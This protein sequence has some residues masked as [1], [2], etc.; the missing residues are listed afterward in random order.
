MMTK[1]EDPT[2]DIRLA[3]GY[4]KQL[5]STSVD[6]LERALLKDKSGVTW[7]K[8]YQS[9]I[10]LL[11]MY[12]FSQAAMRWIDIVGFARRQNPTDVAREMAYL[13]MYFF[14]VHL[15]QGMPT[16]ICTLCALHGRRWSAD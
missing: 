16:D 5:A 4:Y 9:T 10:K 6:T 8:Y 3:K 11:Q 15:G 13:S 14:E 12:G 2:V 1:G 7:A